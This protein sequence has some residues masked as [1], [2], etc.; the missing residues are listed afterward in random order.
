MKK[1]KKNHFTKNLLF[2]FIGVFVFGFGAIV[3]W[4]SFLKLPDFKTFAEQKVKSSTKIYDRTGEILL[5]NVH[6]DIKRTV[7]SSDK[8]SLNIKNASIAIE[9]SE[10]YQHKGIRVSSII[11]AT[12]WTKLTGKK[13]QGGSTITQQLIKNSLLNSDRTITRKIKEWILA[14]K[15]EKLLSKQEIL[16]L[17]LNEAPF[18]GN[19]YGVEEAS[20]NFFGVHAR[21]VNLAQ[22][23]YLA[24]IP[25][26]P[27]R[28]SPYGKNKI[29]LEARKNLVL[30]RMFDLKFIDKNQYDQAKSENVVFLDQQLTHIKAPHFV[31]YLKDQLEKKYGEDIIE[32][33]GLRIISTIDYNLQKKA[34]EVALSGALLN[35]SKYSGSNAAVVAIDPKT[36]QILAMVGS[37]YYFDKKIDGN[38]NVTTS[39]R[40][41]GSTF[42]P[43]VYAL[44][45][46]KGYTDQTTLFDVKTEFNSSCDPSALGKSPC[47]SPDNFDNKFR[48]P[49]TLRQALA[50]SRNVIAVKLLYLVGIKDAITFSHDLGITTLNDGADRY[51]LSLV[52]GGGETTLLDIT[53][54]F[55]VFANEGVRH[56]NNSI[57]SIGDDSGNILEKYEEKSYDVMDANSARLLS[58]VL[59]DNGARAKTFGLN[60]NM[61]IPNQDVAVK[62]G[63]TNDNKDAW[64]VGYTPSIAVGVWTGNNDNKKMTNGGEKVAGPI[65]KQ[66]MTYALT[67]TT[68]EK[69]NPTEQIDPT[70]PSFL[71]GLW[72]G[73]VTYSIDIDSNELATEL[74]PIEKKKDVS[75]TDVH[76]I[77]HWMNKENPKVLKTNP[78]KSDSQYDNWEYGVLNWWKTNSI[79]YPQITIDNKPK[80]YDN[81]HTEKNKPSLSISGLKDIVYKKTDNIE[82]IINSTSTHPINKIDVFL[83]GKYIISIK[84]SPFKLVLQLDQIDNLKKENN[85]QLIAYDNFGNTGDY[86]QIIKVE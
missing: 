61:F 83:N 15:I 57:I 79:N 63:T 65:W 12:V 72:Q 64:M 16:T 54:A 6:E 52:I 40:Q 73:S 58:S 60:S 39:P 71:R 1:R 5:F 9:D 28:F 43:I 53:S 44:A 56:P 18:G 67:K 26:A 11:R 35:E 14:I 34:E 85:L 19:T 47:Y 78:G 38:F 49:L 75:I 21:D 17:Y 76:T 8:I 24:A 10:F 55:G 86:N 32:N 22:A 20:L 84:K 50:E 2:I 77:L 27:T 31:F 25:N 13:I 7:V 4:A 81:I 29:N 23:A 82:I 51:G 48:G 3:I 46:Q 69:F 74:T 41:P 59:S 66:V 45:F 68:G 80:N 30:K 37:R 70:L 62:T 33:G 42:K 36:G